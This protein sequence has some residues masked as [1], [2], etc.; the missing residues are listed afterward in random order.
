MIGA[1]FGQ[2][3]QMCWSNTALTPCSLPF[4]LSSETETIGEY[5]ALY[6]R[7]RTDMKKQLHE[8]DVLLR[9]LQQAMP[10]S[11]F[12]TLPPAQGQSSRLPYESPSPTAWLCL[13]GFACS[14]S[15][16]ST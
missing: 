13:L 7:Q 9:K 16:E 4:Q 15:H 8:K 6:H 3:Y 5:I 10:T 14:S 1:W 11:A 12:A 2:S